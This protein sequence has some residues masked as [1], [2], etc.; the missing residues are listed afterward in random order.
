MRVSVIQQQ[1]NRV[2]RS[3]LKCVNGGDEVEIFLYSL[4]RVTFVNKAD[5]IRCE[6]HYK[7][8]VN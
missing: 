1:M 5:I 3:D 8:D 2:T 7:V 6:E 4:V